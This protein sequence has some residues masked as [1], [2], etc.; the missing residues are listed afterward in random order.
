MENQLEEQST[1]EMISE[2]AHLVWRWSW[3]LVSWAILAGVSAYYLSSRQTPVYQASAL[4]MINIAPSSVDSA[5]Y[6]SLGQQL[7]E[8]Y[9]Q[10]MTTRPVLDAAAQRL[11]LEYLP[12]SVQV[13]PITNT[14][15]L[16]V[17]VIDT[18]P[19]RAALIANTLVTVFSEQIQAD[20]A[21]RYAD[22]KQNL[23]TQLDA[24]DGQIQ[25]TSGDLAVLGQEILRD[26]TALT[27]LLRTDNITRTQEELDQRASLI[28]QTQSSLQSRLSQQAQMQT[29][30]QNYRTSYAILLQSYE[31]VRL[32]ESQSSSGVL[33]KDPAV[34]NAIPIQ[35]QPIRSALLAAV[36][37]L[38]LAGG[39][40]FLIE[41]L[42]DTIRDPQEITRKWGIPILGMITRY[43]SNGSPLITIKQPRAPV[44]EAFRSLRTNLEFAAV[45]SPL[46]TILITS[47]SPQDGKTTIVSNLACVIAQSNRSVVVVDAD[48]RRPQIH[49]Y[50]QLM[51][52]L[53]LSN[54]LLRPH[55]RVD[56]SLQD[57]ELAGLKVITSGRLPPDPSELLGSNKM[58]EMMNSLTGQFEC[59]I[60]DSPPV[61]VVT[62][63]VVL[64]PRV[65]GV[66]I[67]VKPSVTKRAEL[68]HVIEQM[69]QVNARL[70]GV[71][72]NDVDVGRS[73]YYY[74]RRYSS[75]Y[76]YKYYKGYYSPDGS[77]KKEKTNAPESTEKHS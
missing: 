2:Y 41:F 55:D 3:L 72:L 10:L 40:I 33:L 32:A 25:T 51:N 48:L 66:I 64:A 30:L 62:D 53:G 73:R 65:N 31:S 68:Q 27:D 16:N 29:I 8:S 46:K 9:S 70:L 18:D 21:A 35:P 54:Q 59:V 4:A 57:T 6:V 13:T 15:L 50:F 74:Y 63:A 5:Y 77:S 71:V 26:N 49:K 69:N 19:E 42:D 44:S 12:G 17:R 7:G 34:P 56:G 1:A 52:R 36:V 75:S 37:G 14:Q 43:K 61:L 76:K 22:S 23:K 47:P 24:L 20:Q 67:V 45:D 38:L 58:Q 28:Q 39:V 11:G 60:L